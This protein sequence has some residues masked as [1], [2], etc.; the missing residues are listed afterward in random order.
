MKVDRG[1]VVFP[2]AEAAGHFF[3]HLNLAIQAFSGGSGGVGEAMPKKDK[4]LKTHGR[5]E[6]VLLPVLSRPEVW[7]S[8][9][10]EQPAEE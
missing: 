1:L 2:I 7:Y 4:L 6:L 8:T 10:G 5:Q 9:A 3:H